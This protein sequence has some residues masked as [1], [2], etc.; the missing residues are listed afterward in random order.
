MIT[1]EMTPQARQALDAL[2]ERLD[3]LV[4]AWQNQKAGN[5]FAAEYLVPLSKQPGF[6]TERDDGGIGPVDLV[7]TRLWR[8]WLDNPDKQD[9]NSPEHEYPE[10]SQ[11]FH[12][13]QAYI[14]NTLSK[15]AAVQ[16]KQPQAP[17]LIA[18]TPK[19]NA[20][21]NDLPLNPDAGPHENSEGVLPHKTDWSQTLFLALRHKEQ[22][23]FTWI[24]QTRP[25]WLDESG[26]IMPLSELGDETELTPQQQMERDYILSELALLRDFEK[27]GMLYLQDHHKGEAFYSRVGLDGFNSDSF[28][29]N[30]ESWVTE[31]DANKIARR[32]E[33]SLTQSLDHWDTVGECMDRKTIAGKAQM[34]MMMAREKGQSMEE[35]MYKDHQDSGSTR[36]ALLFQSNW[37]S[38][39]KLLALEGWIAQYQSHGL[40]KDKKAYQELLEEQGKATGDAEK[41]A[42]QAFE[43]RVKPALANTVQIIEGLAER[44][45]YPIPDVA[46]QYANGQIQDG[47]PERSKAG[48]EVI[49]VSLD[50]SR[51]HP[52]LLRHLKQQTTQDRVWQTQR[53][54]DAVVMKTAHDYADMYGYLGERSIMFDDEDLRHFPAGH[55]SSQVIQKHEKTIRELTQSV[56]Q[57]SEKLE[58]TRKLSVN[59]RDSMLEQFK[60]RLLTL[61]GMLQNEAKHLMSSARSM[62]YPL[63]TIKED[64]PR[65]IALKKNDMSTE[66]V[67]EHIIKEEAPELKSVRKALFPHN[68]T[69]TS[70]QARDILGDLVGDTSHSSNLAIMGAARAP[71]NHDK[72]MAI[73]RKEGRDTFGWNKDSLAK[74][75]AEAEQAHQAKMGEKVSPS[76]ANTPR[77][78]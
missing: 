7:G 24:N 21:L 6:F 64:N 19:P 56:N 72:M 59:R 50:D 76:S 71:I 31:S 13:I 57:L 17:W 32:R 73:R 66:G 33:R 70:E 12:R 2:H 65:Y 45:R 39:E 23:L 34:L 51:L 30:S 43:D 77:F 52:D 35:A 29:S 20:L 1:M 49:G 37:L 48:L 47:A 41:L 63:P 9:N 11:S 74:A 15:G 54:S 5:P 36:Q 16:V 58:E 42:H 38:R 26:E 55:P 25:E 4:N 60:G 78:I 28:R 14:E 40:E 46:A 44:L 69:I 67:P 27:Q 18:T 22:T 75:N 68:E 62:G 10:W 8:H 3:A 53:G 61:E